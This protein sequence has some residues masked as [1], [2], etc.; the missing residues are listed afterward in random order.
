MTYSSGYPVRPVAGRLALDFVNTADWTVD[1]LVFHEKIAAMDDVAT[2]LDAIGL[3]EAGCPENIETLHLFRRDLRRAML[4][5]GGGDVCG[6]LDRIRDIDPRRALG[7]QPLLAILATSALAI[8]A[9]PRE[10]R[11]IK[12]CPG[13]NCGWLF[14]DETR[15]GRRKWCMMETCGNR[16]KSARHYER[17]IRDAKSG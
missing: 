7:R 4:P 13:S 14:V 3:S 11:R 9:D 2:W 15:N 16:A 1:G 8:L 6:F 10:V 12:L 5:N 17:S